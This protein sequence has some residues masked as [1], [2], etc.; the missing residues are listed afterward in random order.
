MATTL[1]NFDGAESGRIGNSDLEFARSQGERPE[2]VEGVLRISLGPPRARMLVAFDKQV[3]RKLEGRAAPL[4]SAAA[5]VPRRSEVPWSGTNR[6][7]G[8][9]QAR[10]F[11]AGAI[12]ESVTVPV[13]DDEARPSATATRWAEAQAQ[14]EALASAYAQLL[15]DRAQLE[16][17]WTRAMPTIERLLDRYQWL[18]PMPGV[19]SY[20]WSSRAGLSSRRWRSAFAT[21]VVHLLRRGLRWEEALRPRL[22]QAHPPSNAPDRPPPRYRLHPTLELRCPA[23]AWPPTVV[24]DFGSAPCGAHTRVAILR[25][26]FVSNSIDVVRLPAREPVPVK[27]LQLGI[28]VDSWC[29]GFSANLPA[30]ALELVEP[31]AAGPVELEVRVNGI[32]WVVL[33]EGY[34]IRREFASAALTVRGR[35]RV[36]YLAE[37]YAPKRSFAPATA[38]TARQLAEAELMRVAPDGREFALDWQLPDWLVPAGSWSYESLEPIGAIAR[39]VQAVGGYLNAQPRLATL[40]AK[41]RYPALPWEWAAAPAARTLPIDVVKTVSLRWRELPAF[42]AVFVSGER[43]GVTAR[44]RRSGSA[45]DRAAPM[46]VDPLITHADATRERARAV[47]A[48][49]GRQALVTLELPMLDSIGLLDPG[50]LLSVVDAASDWRGLVRATSVSAAWSD[51]LAVRQTVEVERHYR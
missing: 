14:H 50:T 38:F 20:A 19:G 32:A 2:P 18:V 49:T 4:W 36:A 51:T 13:G 3:D 23:M 9:A 33:V 26:Y 48:D 10:W 7:R 15:S 11:A 12:G 44:A 29:W 28:D 5:A 31:T 25:V 30:A 6:R 8:T 17:A 34:E 24:L 47:L 42:N 27:A 37:P 21:A 22:G 35:S 46:V 39:I 1:L 41:P 16:L 45:G 40:V 43:V